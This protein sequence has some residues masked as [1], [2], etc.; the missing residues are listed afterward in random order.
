M[1]AQV[2]LPTSIVIAIN[3]LI[4]IFSSIFYV[5]VFQYDYI[6]IGKRHRLL[7]ITMAGIGIAYQICSQLHLL[8]STRVSAHLE[9][10]A[11]NSYL[12]SVSFAEVHFSKTLIPIAPMLTKGRL[13][14]LR[15]VSISI[16]TVTL[17]CRIAGIVMA[18]SSDIGDNYKTLQEISDYA[19]IALR[20]WSFITLDPLSIYCNNRLTAY[21]K[22][23]IV[24]DAKEN[25]DSTAATGQAIILDLENIRK[26]IYTNVAIDMACLTLSFIIYL[27]IDEWIIFGY[28]GGFF[29]LF[30]SI[31][32]CY[33]LARIVLVTFPNATV[34]RLQKHRGKKLVVA[35]E[36]MV[37]ESINDGSIATR[38]IVSGVAP[39]K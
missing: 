33:L 5:A 36:L 28:L 21:I 11:F 24:S 29:F 25:T 39:R 31:I 2:N 8:V 15:A 27:P 13:N 35:K 17:I 20:A 38:I 14:G 12:L 22:R 37:S 34:V 3:T 7:A 18:I 10:I 1:I 30:H 9:N 32:Y 16:F 19:E 4:A 26:M 23:K 6:H